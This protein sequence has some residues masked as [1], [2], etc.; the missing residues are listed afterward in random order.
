[1]V[2]LDD[3]AEYNLVMSAD[4]SKFDYSYVPEHLQTRVK[5]CKN[6]SFSERFDLTHQLSVAAW[7]KIGVARDSSKPMERTIRR[8]TRLKD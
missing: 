3:S 4:E 5:K 2:G 7:V 6:L 1:L 8:V